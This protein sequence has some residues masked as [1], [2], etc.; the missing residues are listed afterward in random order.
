[1]K[2]AM[3]QEGVAISE[4]K[5]RRIMRE[6]GLYPVTTLKFKPAKKGKTTGNYF[7]HVINQNFSPQGFN[8]I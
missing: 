8:E 2:R 4:H 5:I 1:M 6:N 3:E 7:E